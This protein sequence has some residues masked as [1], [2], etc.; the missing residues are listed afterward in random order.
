MLGSCQVLTNQ[1]YGW[2]QIK[3]HLVTPGIDSSLWDIKSDLI[4]KGLT[5]LGKGQ[6]E[7]LVVGHVKS[8]QRRLLLEFL[9]L[10][11]LPVGVVRGLE[12]AVVRDVLAQRLLPAQ[13][14]CHEVV[15]RILQGKN[16]FIRSN[17]R[18]AFRY[19]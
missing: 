16:Y 9:L 7:K 2:H 18:R 19:L 11:P 14:L 1:S 5:D 8:G 10:Q 3:A 4:S 6:E 12:P 13:V 17:L 15:G